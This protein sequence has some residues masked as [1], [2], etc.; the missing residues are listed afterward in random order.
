M[1]IIFFSIT[2]LFFLSPILHS[3][4]S[5]WQVLPTAPIADSSALRFDD[6]F[7]INPSTGWVVT[8]GYTN[9][10]N[11]RGYVDTCKIYNTTDGGVS[12]NVSY[13]VGPSYLR[14]IGFV[15]ANTGVLGTLDSLHYLYRTTNGGVNW[16]EV[17]NVSGSVPYGVCGMSVVPNSNTIYG[18]GRYWGKATVIKSTDAGV[19]WKSLNINGLANTLI[20]CKFWSADTGIIVGGLHPNNY[21]LNG[22]AVILYTSDGGNSWVKVYQSNRTFEWCWKTF[23]VDRNLG[24]VSI[25]KEGQPTNILKT[26]NGGLNWKEIHITNNSISD[27]EGLG[28]LNENT[29]W[30]GGWG[31]NYHLPTYETTNGGINWHLA[32]WGM[33]MD[34]VR[35]LS[36]TLAYAVG[37]QVYKYTS[38]P[39][40]IIPVSNEVPEHFKLEQNFP[41]P[42]NPSTKIRFEIPKTSFTKLTIYDAAG[43]ETTF[44]INEQLSA[45]SYEVTWNASNFPSGIYFYRLQ[46]ELQT[47]SGQGFTE[48]KKMI[49]IK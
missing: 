8:T 15:D 37:F 27:L 49:L 16:A 47:G 25:E 7:F 4:T 14:C 26:V 9:V 6:V 20:D 34:R 23:F 39:L 10:K 45:G 48:S 30:I 3:Q 46:T 36:D 29:G 40:G 19:S 28:F 21:L 12:W 2:I 41:N 22:N 17:T 38:E 18:V 43:R 1:K 13:L 11:Y 32:G 33:N 31:S 5:S 35:F 24:F 44:L 42:F